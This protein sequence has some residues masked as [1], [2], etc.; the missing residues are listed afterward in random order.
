VK[1]ENYRRDK[2]SEN[3][4]QENEIL[5]EQVE[6]SKPKASFIKS[7]SAIIVDEVIIGIISIIVLFVFEAL[8]KLG[9]YFISQKISIT[10]L[11]FVVVSILYTSIMETKKNGNT[12][13]KKLLIY[14]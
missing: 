1:W 13:G 6:I 2:M 4:V 11:I 5:E 3:N 14:K 9:G 10:F 12:I 8:L 7:L